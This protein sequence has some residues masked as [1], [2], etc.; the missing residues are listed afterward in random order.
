MVQVEKAAHHLADMEVTFLILLQNG[1]VPARH[2]FAFGNCTKQV[3]D[4]VLGL[5]PWHLPPSIPS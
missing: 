3:L 2:A 1:I 5:D 4:I